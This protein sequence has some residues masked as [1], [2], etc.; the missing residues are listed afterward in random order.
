MLIKLRAGISAGR[1]TRQPPLSLAGARHPGGDQT[2]DAFQAL[3]AQHASAVPIPWSAD[4]RRRVDRFGEWSVRD[5]RRVTTPGRD[6]VCTGTPASRHWVASR[7]AA[8]GG[9]ASRPGTP[10]A[11]AAET[12]EPMHG[13][14]GQGEGAP[15][16]HGGRGGRTAAARRAGWHR[17]RAGGPLPRLRVPAARPQGRGPPAPRGLRAA[18]VGRQS[19]SAQSLLTTT[20]RVLRPPIKALLDSDRPVTLLPP[21]ACHLSTETAGAPEKVM[22]YETAAELS[23]AAG[24]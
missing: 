1:D 15:R 19:S 3:R 23:R 9:C 2:T 8:R 14:G 6:R 7:R 24:S 12:H 11:R 20:T 17:G 18:P 13:D 4:Q 21:G 10:R 5:A 22:R 16:G